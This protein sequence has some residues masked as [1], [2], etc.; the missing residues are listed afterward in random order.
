ME[1]ISVWFGGL[2]SGMKALVVV[3]SLVLFAVLSPLIGPL[4]MLFFIVCV[5]VVAYRMLR[6]RPYR[7]SGIFLPGS[8]AVLLLANGVSGALYGTC[9]NQAGSTSDSRSQTE[10]TQARQEG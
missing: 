6:G 3:A 5:P 4:A 8:L 9:S 10:K 2:T 1:R 7:R